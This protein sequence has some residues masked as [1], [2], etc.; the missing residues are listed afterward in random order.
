MDGLLEA[1]RSRA[2]LAAS[3]ESGT[4][5]ASRVVELL[6]DDRVLETLRF[7]AIAV[8]SRRG[9][10]FRTTGSSYALG[11]N[12]VSS[13][14]GGSGLGTSL[15]TGGG[16]CGFASV[17]IEADRCRRILLSRAGLPLVTSCSEV[18]EGERVR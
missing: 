7:L 8:D 15:T 16:G 4:D 9:R 17:S 11:I 18:S 13:L 5:S 1:L 10:L 2:R 12:A 14:G 6:R 3:R